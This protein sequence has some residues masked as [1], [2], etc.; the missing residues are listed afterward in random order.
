MI[1]SNIPHQ[2]QKDRTPAAY[3]LP[4]LIDS[5][6]PLVAIKDLFEISRSFD[7]S[8]GA[9]DVE[10]FEIALHETLRQYTP[11]N[12]TFHAV[13]A[14]NLSETLEA[15]ADAETKRA[16]KNVG[17]VHLDK[18]IG[19]NS[20]NPSYARLDLSRNADN[21]LVPRV[22]TQ[23]TPEEQMA[24]LL[25]WAQ[26]G[27]YDQLV[28]VDDVLAF[29]STVPPL[30]ERLREHLPDTEF[31]LLVGLA[32][33]GGAWRGIEKVQEDTGIATEYLTKII[34]SKTTERGSKGMS[35]PV[36][37]DLTL[38][39]GKAGRHESGAQLSYPYFLPF[40]K[41]LLSLFDRDKQLEGSYAM[42]DFNDML[43]ASI[44]ARVGREL[45]VGDLTAAGYGVPFTSIDD[46]KEIMQLPTQ[47]MT[48]R[49]YN[50]HARQILV[51]YGDKLA[52]ENT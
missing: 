29:G 52:R 2:E 25:Q 24:K 47:D 15:I 32:T 49:A 36:S 35:I 26:A 21:K 16:D 5:P 7:P 3:E 33:S 4:P 19:A 48:L 22:G 11:A 38:F 31:R 8:L 13:G 1:E 41:P 45:T 20:D 50:D 40:S 14:T 10:P 39:G 18:Y 30:I 9:E 42:L 28:L 34:P 23:A 12:T 6:Y 43:V 17:I 46:L 44:E 27:N 51:E 37:R